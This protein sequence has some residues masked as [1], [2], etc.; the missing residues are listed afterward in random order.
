[1]P[2]AQALPVIGVPEQH[3]ITVVLLYVIEFYRQGYSL[4]GLAHQTE[5]M[6]S[7]KPRARLA[8]T[9]AVQDVLIQ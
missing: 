2:K 6:L 1:M 7:K 8:V 5:W 3:R 4:L 9:P